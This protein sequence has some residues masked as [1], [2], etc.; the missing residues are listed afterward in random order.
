MLATMILTLILG[1]TP[2]SPPVLSKAM[3]QTPTKL[4]PPSKAA[5]QAVAAPQC[6]AL[7]C[8]QVAVYGAPANSYGYE[9]TYTERYAGAPQG[10]KG[11]HPF[12]N[13]HPFKK[14]LGGGCGGG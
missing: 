4:T 11:F 13:F 8:P 5:P 1:Q 12:K 10:K 6:S 14:G 3:P 2:Q 9:V 7:G